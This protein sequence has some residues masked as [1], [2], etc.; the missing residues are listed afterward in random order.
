MVVK[1]RTYTTRKT[2]AYSASKIDKGSFLMRKDIILRLTKRAKL[3]PIGKWKAVKSNSGGQVFKLPNGKKIIVKPEL[4]IPFPNAKIA[5]NPD[6]RSRNMFLLVN[7]LLRRR[8]KIEVPLGEI[9]TKEGRKFYIT[10][11]VN[12]ETLSHVLGGAPKDVQKEIARRT[13]KT[14]AQ[15][16]LRG[17]IHGHPH[18]SNWIVSVKDGSLRLIDVK[19]ITFKEEYPWHTNLGRTHTFDDMRENDIKYFF[20][21]NSKLEREFLST[22]RAE[23][24]KFYKPK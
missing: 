13:A 8:V 12:G 23:Y 9:V 21:G 14:L 19:H 18:N 7:E 2:K 10:E 11:I 16:H 4:W 22:F 6:G 17:V 20:K 5:V 1:K 15:V 24:E 3:P